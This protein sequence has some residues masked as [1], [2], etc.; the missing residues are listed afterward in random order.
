MLVAS[1]ISEYHRPG[2]LDYYFSQFWN[3]EVRDQ[4]DGLIVFWWESFSRLQNADFLLDPLLGESGNSKQ[5]L[6]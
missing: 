3:L 2:S 5:T 6:L 1:C 4:G